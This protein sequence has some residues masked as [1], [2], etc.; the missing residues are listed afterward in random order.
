MALRL[1][2]TKQHG[3]ALTRIS[4]PLASRHIQSAYIIG[5]TSS[6]ARVV[7]CDDTRSVESKLDGPVGNLAVV[8]QTAGPLTNLTERLLSDGVT[9]LVQMQFTPNA[10]NSYSCGLGPI[11]P[12]QGKPSLG[13]AHRWILATADTNDIGLTK[14]AANLN[15]SRAKQTYFN[16]WTAIQSGR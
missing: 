13:L 12:Q 3:I 4:V 15:V 9:Y 7:L 10:P 8:S 16:A 1:Y 2:R 14:T 5:G 11:P 6:T